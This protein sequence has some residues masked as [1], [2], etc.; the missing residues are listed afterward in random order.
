MVR[1][2]AFTIASL[3]FLLCAGQAAAGP[4]ACSRGVVDPASPV[5]GAWTLRQR[6][7][8]TGAWTGPWTQDFRRDGAY[9]QEGAIVGRW[10][11]V[12]D[13][14]LLFGF[15]SAPYTVYRATIAPTVM[16]GTESW[17]NGGTG[18]FELIRP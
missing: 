10:C 13:T 4:F 6:D 17:D 9:L 12:D 8:D 18:E 16:R 5:I 3:V 11:I 14:V 2:F 1:L 15:D 7:D